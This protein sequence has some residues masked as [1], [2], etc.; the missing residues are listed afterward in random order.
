MTG[1]TNL[2]TVHKYQ[3]S[4]FLSLCHVSSSLYSG[5]H[6]EEPNPCYAMLA[7]LISVSTHR[8]HETAHTPEVQE[9]RA[10]GHRASGYQD[11]ASLDLVVISY[12]Q[13]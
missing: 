13:F 5:E 4:F 2:E 1:I 9:V 3:P 12:Q 6:L 10:I 7:H 8:Q 11:Q